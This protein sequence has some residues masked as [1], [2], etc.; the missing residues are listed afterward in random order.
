MLVGLIGSGQIM[1]HGECVLQFD[2]SLRGVDVVFVACEQTEVEPM[3]LVANWVDI[4]P[5]ISNDIMEA[6]NIDLAHKTWV[7]FDHYADSCTF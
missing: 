4:E 1:P 7:L 6:S 3:M 2:G 5:K